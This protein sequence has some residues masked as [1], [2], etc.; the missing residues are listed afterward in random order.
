[1]LQ[2]R[3][4]AVALLEG[5][6]FDSSG[7]RYCLPTRAGVACYRGMRDEVGHW[8][9]TLVG[10][11]SSADDAA[12]FLDGRYVPLRKTHDTRY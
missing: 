6:G 9:G 4:K 10:I 12:R 7:T 3:R 8:K 1:M 11:A 2:R 5:A